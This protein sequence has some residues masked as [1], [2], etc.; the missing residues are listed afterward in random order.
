MKKENLFKHHQDVRLF[1][2]LHIYIL[3][4]SLTRGGRAICSR[5]IQVSGVTFPDHESRELPSSLMHAR[6][7]LA[8]MSPRILPDDFPQRAVGVGS[9]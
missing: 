3:W 1:F 9:Y 6:L 4:N 8:P 5:R 7:E 2:S